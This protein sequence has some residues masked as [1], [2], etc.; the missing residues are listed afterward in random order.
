MRILTVTALL[1]AGCASN[2]NLAAQRNG[3]TASAFS[4]KADVYLSG[5]EWAEGTYAF[6][7]TDRHGN[8]LTEV[9]RGRF[10]R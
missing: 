4:K 2:A 8:A 10:L 9:L 1:A 7:V 6:E 3:A 5:G